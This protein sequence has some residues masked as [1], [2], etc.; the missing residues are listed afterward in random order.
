MIRRILKGLR[1]SHKIALLSAVAALA[2]VLVFL[3]A[4]LSRKTTDILLTQ[5]ETGYLPAFNLSRNLDEQF[6]LARRTLEDAAAAGDL[7][8]LPQADLIR[9]HILQILQN[10][11]TNPTISKTDIDILERSFQSYYNTA[12][13]ATRSMMLDEVGE[14]MQ[15]SLQSM[16]VKYVDLSVQLSLF[17][18][19]AFR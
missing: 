15:A 19:N 16:R 10:G 3:L 18:G 7:S 6:L 12:R 14:P 17:A 11:R 13:A 4:E 1:F 5:I 8:K 9:D 2:F